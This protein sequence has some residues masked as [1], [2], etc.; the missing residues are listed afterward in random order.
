VLIEIDFIAG[1]TELTS[2]PSF[3]SRSV[4]VSVYGFTLLG[5]LDTIGE[6]VMSVV[7]IT[8]SIDTMYIYM[9]VRVR[10]RVCLSYSSS[11]L[12]IHPCSPSHHPLPTHYIPPAL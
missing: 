11:L 7:D 5:L 4:L 3:L 6:T 1:F 8:V 12:T 10:V 2:I 9:C